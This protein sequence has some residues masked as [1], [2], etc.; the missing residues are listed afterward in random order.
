ME[1]VES[2]CSKIVQN[3]KGT[4]ILPNSIQQNT[5]STS[6][7][8]EKRK[9]NSRHSN[10][11]KHKYFCLQVANLYVVDPRVPTHTYVCA[12]THTHINY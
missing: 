10:L 7:S 3:K 4:H 12:H 6:Q 9:R 1:K 5:G 2:V 8:K 11:K